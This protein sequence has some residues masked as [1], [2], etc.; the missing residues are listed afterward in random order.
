MS[1]KIPLTEEILKQI[2]VKYAEIVA[3]DVKRINSESDISKVPK[4]IS[5]IQQKLNEYAKYLY[6]KHGR[7]IIRVGPD[8]F[9]YLDVTSPRVKISQTKA[10]VY[11]LETD[12]KGK[13]VKDPSEL[14][15]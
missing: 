7:I 8:E 4:I 14:E 2:Q 5:E 15:G 12:K 13:P 1:I 3:E 10:M 9:D 11:F 6:D